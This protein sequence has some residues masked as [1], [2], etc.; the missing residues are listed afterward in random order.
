MNGTHFAAVSWLF[1]GLASARRITM[2]PQISRA[3]PTTARTRYRTIAFGP[4]ASKRTLVSALIAAPP[5][6]ATTR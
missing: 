1:A 3:T 6:C 2:M 4:G 5:A